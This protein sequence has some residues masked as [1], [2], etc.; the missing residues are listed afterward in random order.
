M[1][2][3][4]LNERIVK[5]SEFKDIFPLEQKEWKKNRLAAKSCSS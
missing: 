5:Y 4:I 1:I 2:T 3:S